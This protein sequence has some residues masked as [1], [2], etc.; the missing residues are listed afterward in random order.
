MT[1]PTDP[2]A[3]PEPRLSP[4]MGLAMSVGENGSETMW[5]EVI[6]RM[7]EVY[8]ELLRNETDLERK[9]AQ[10]QEA[11][12]FISSVIDSVSDILLVCSGSGQIKTAN[13]AFLQLVGLPESKVLGTMIGTYVADEDHAVIAQ[14]LSSGQERQVHEVD[15]HFRAASGPDETMAMRC[16]PLFDASRRRMGAV[17]TGRPISE[18]RRAYQALHEAHLD[19]QRAQSKLIEQE[20]M[21]SLGRL[22]AG[23][24]HELN[25]PISFVYGNIYTLERY[26]KSLTAYIDA[27]HRRES[28]PTLEE[29]RGSLRIDAILADMQP[30]LEGTLEGA[31]RVSDIVKNLR[32][33]S[34]SRSAERQSVD[35]GRLLRNASH[36][37]ARAK[38]SPAQI[39]ISAPDNLFLDTHEGQVHQVMVNMID[40][41]LDAVRGLPDA[42]VWLTLTR[43]GDTIVLDVA[44]NGP[45]IPDSARDKIFEPF[46]TTKTVGEGTGLGLW[47]S[48]GIMREFG[49]QLTAGDRPGGGALFRA[50][51]PLPAA[52]G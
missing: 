34:F 35:L 9:N 22:V 46:F 44:D 4:L 7:E 6:H 5:V 49:G 12:T 43:E 8:S 26:R 23:V 10:L 3:V 19:L 30:L 13:P 31:V 18:L 33:L 25:N 38:N 50:T 39:I 47:I 48:F 21:A 11:Q 29:M 42:K 2:T 24:A 27:M 40:N 16:A 52:A 28:G 1:T 51:F 45:G 15:L 41:A 32:R 37:A 17:L 36:L 20:K 14:L